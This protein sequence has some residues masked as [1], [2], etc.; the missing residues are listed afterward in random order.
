VDT[1][2][3]D[4]SGLE[5]LWADHPDCT[6]P[7]LPVVVQ[8]NILEHLSSHGL[9]RFESLA[10]D[11]LDLEAVKEALGASV[12]VAVALGAHAA[13]KL[14]AGQQRLIQRRAI[15]APAIGVNYHALRHLP[16]PQ[17]HLQGITYQVGGH[18]LTHRP[19][20]YLA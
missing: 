16:A 4:H 2:L 3:S 11:G 7:T 17:S 9:P 19:A 20:D 8:F 15:L 5:G 6:V 1:D 18:P 14:V 13:L 12:V 10:M